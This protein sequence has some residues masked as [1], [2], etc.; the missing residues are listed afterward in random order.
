MKK[1]LAA[2][3]TVAVLTIGARVALAQDSGQVTIKDPAEYNAYSSIESA[4]GAAAKAANIESFLTSYP[5]SVVKTVVLEELMTAYTQVPDLDKALGAANRLLAENPNS[6]RGMFIKVYIEKSKAD[7]L[8]DAAAKLALLDDAAQ[9]ANAG[10]TARKPLSVTDADFSKLKATATPI[11]YSAL[12]E[13]SDAKKDYASAE[14]DYMAELKSVPVAQTVTPGPYLQDTFYFGLEYYNQRPQDFLSCAYYTLRA[15]HYAPEPYKGQM[16]PTAK[17]CF[18]KYIGPHAADGQ[19]IEK[20]ESIAATSLD[21]SADLSKQFTQY[22][23]PK[24]E[25]VAHQALVGATDPAALALSDKEYILANATQEDTD[26]LWAI[27]NGASTGEF[28][29]KVVSVAAD[30]TQIQLA[31]TD[32]AKTGNTADF[33][34]TMKTPITENVPVNG[35][36]IKISGTFSSFTKSPFLFTLTDGVIPVV[37]KAPVKKPVHHTAA[38]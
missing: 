30:G 2:L 31:V 9:T 13:D 19:T 21:I 34:V 17:Y 23:P 15:A 16:M 22:I 4:T 36:T 26:K 5:N 3:L 11:F 14:K 8:Q 7:Q 12:A 33:A 27:L 38:H 35:S 24:P 1:A 6:L 37:K 20:L 25:D 28:E 10:L 18:N 29:G 32:D